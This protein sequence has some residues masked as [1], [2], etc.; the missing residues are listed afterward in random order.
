[1]EGITINKIKIHGTDK[2]GEIKYDSQSV[3]PSS[4]APDVVF[5]N[6]KADKAIE[7][8][9]S[10]QLR[11]SYFEVE[12]TKDSS[13]SSKSEVKLGWSKES[14]TLKFGDEFVAPALTKSVA[15][16]TVTYASD[17]ADLLAVDATTGAMTLTPN[18][19]GT[20]TITASIAPD[21]EKY[22][23]T[24]AR[25]TLSVV[26]P[27]TPFSYV[28]AMGTDFTFENPTGLEV[29]QHDDTYGLKGSAFINRTTNAATAIAASRVLDLTN[30]KNI[31]LDFQNAFNNYKKNNVMIDVADFNGYAYVVVKEEGE[32][33]WT[34]VCEATAP[35]EF[36]WTFYNNAQIDLSAYSN[37]KIQV[38]F[39]YVSTSDV[40]GTWEV[41]NIKVAAVAGQT[42]PVDPAAEVPV[43]TVVEEDW[44]NQAASTV[45]V[46][47]KVTLSAPEGMEDWLMA[48]T[49]NN[50]EEEL[51][52][53][54][55]VLTIDEE[56]TISAYFDEENV[57]TR[58]FKVAK[59]PAPTLSVAFGS[60]ADNSEVTVS[61]PIEGAKL[62][63]YI[64]NEDMAGK[65]LPYT[66]AV[67]DMV[68]VCIHAEK[69]R[70][71]NSDEVEGIYTI[72]LPALPATWEPVT[73][74]DQ[75]NDGDVV[76]FM[77]KEYTGV[78]SNQDVT[79]PAVIMKNLDSDVIKVTEFTYDEKKH[80]P[81]DAM[82]FTLHT[83]KEGIITLYNDDNNGYLNST[84]NKKV[85]FTTEA[86][87]L[88]LSFGSDGNAIVGGITISNESYTLRYNPNVKSPVDITSARFTFYTSGQND[89]YMFRQTGVELTAPS[90]DIEMNTTVNV[91][92]IISISCLK[93]AHV[94]IRETPL[95]GNNSDVSKIVAKEDG[96]NNHETHQVN[97]MISQLGQSLEVKAVSA[98]GTLHS[99][100]VKLEV[101]E[102]GVVTSI[103]DIAAAE[104]AAEY[105]DL[106]GRRVARPTKGNLYILK[107]GSKVSKQVF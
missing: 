46:G 50:G 59:L 81:Q 33:E 96:W 44:Y 89:I 9:A 102:N 19:A 4:K 13:N 97:Y 104:G 106:Q 73:A 53:E 92:D 105:F 17:N 10:A 52:D 8:T 65:D 60:V 64:G 47:A 14:E 39:K 32:T 71:I 98:D 58:T 26:D 40:A 74:L 54:A 93:G 66:F 87:E 82:Q 91:G 67:S 85:S 31:T 22:F 57:V 84:K 35:S 5:D 80:L 42:E 86:K 49:V 95:G 16:A 76:T 61:C 21:D 103:A 107:Q 18:V 2:W 48:Y 3:K 34:E 45:Y 90:I 38:G 75:V 55:V 27:N 37:K 78:A 11:F 7:F 63:G 20:A 25:Y 68:N 70:F 23:A 83:A 88:T 51:T 69:E 77:A 30:Y 94:W 43:F 56:T 79:Y 62:W 99:S 100:V 15:D 41:Q 36:S 6:L 12:Y 28:S 29:W 101:S 72:K 1:M 24:P